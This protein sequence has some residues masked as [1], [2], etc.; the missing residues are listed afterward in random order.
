MGF[1]DGI[2]ETLRSIKEKIRPSSRQPSP[3]LANEDSYE[4]GW[5][6]KS[7]VADIQPEGGRGLSEYEN[8]LGFDRSEL[9]GKIVLDLGAGPEV[10]F[11]KD[12]RESNINATVT[13]FSPDFFYKEFREM[14]NQ[15]FASVNKV[16]GL[17]QS[18]PFKD[19]SF[20]VVIA[21]HVLDHLEILGKEVYLRFINEIGRVLTK[22]GKAYI[23]PSRVNLPDLDDICYRSLLADVD[24]M[25]T[26]SNLG[27]SIS[28][29]LIP[30]EYFY[31]KIHIPSMCRPPGSPAISKH[32]GFRI[33]LEK[34]P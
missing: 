33:I 19:N 31:T 30:L 4:G 5:H 11:A 23:G 20:D 12:L 34:K 27:I 17:G 10:K 2:T 16:A 15:S 3:V 6:R 25:N 8:I 28:H 14:A 29:Q 7:I 1:E 9:Q 21:L 18:L 24:T 32:E 13:E 26:L 22:G